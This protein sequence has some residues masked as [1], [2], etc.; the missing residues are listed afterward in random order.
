MSPYYDGTI[1]GRSSVSN[2]GLHDVPPNGARDA[3]A[4]FKDGIKRDASLY[5]ILNDGAIMVV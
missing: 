3:V 2:S 4:N 5:A 1:F